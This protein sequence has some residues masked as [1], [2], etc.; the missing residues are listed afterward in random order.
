MAL[1]SIIVIGA[2]AGGVAA[3]R[4]LAADLIIPLPVPILIVLH[5]G[6]QR[7]ELPSIMNIAGPTPASHG[8]EGALL[9]AGH[10]YIAPPDR[11]MTIVGRRLHLTRGPKENWA[12]PAIDPLFRSAAEGYGTGAIG[13]ILTGNLDDGTAGLYEIK[14]RG[15]IAIA[16]SPMDAAHPDMPRSAANHVDIDYCIPLAEISRLLTTLV[17]EE[18]STV[19]NSAGKRPGRSGPW[20]DL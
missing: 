3:L 16:Q 2:S 13:V 6:A 12:R 11:H 18:N 5:V 1:A 4:T 15:G 8:E 14:Q 9:C 19:A 17:T 10:I 7:S 20:R